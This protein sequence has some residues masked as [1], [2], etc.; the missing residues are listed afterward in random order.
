MENQAP[1]TETETEPKVKAK[2]EPREERQ[3][4]E[5]DDQPEGKVGA[6]SF[7]K[8]KADKTK[9]ELDEIKSKY[10]EML[11]KQKE[12]EETKMVEERKFE[13]LYKREK[14]RAEKA[15]QESKEIKKNFING[16]KYDA[17]EREAIKAGIKENY[18]KFLNFDT[19]LVQIETTDKGRVNVFGAKEFI[20]EF[21]NENPELFK[22]IK[23]A[24]VN[25][26]S[27]AVTTKT[28]EL[29]PKQIVELQQKD[30]QRYKA[31]MTSRLRLA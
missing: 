31:Y 20:E 5:K 18:L 17:I 10:D 6:V 29:T 19:E 8:S 24:T 16:K 3:K 14:E 27:A 1:E 4:E 23:G 30:P 13:T 7:Y 28:E 9:A 21:K 11:A 2:E 25:S 12:M 26:G 15:M 22:T